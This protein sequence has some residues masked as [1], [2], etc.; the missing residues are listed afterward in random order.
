MDRLYV[1]NRRE[2][3]EPFLEPSHH[4]RVRV[5]LE[6]EVDRMNQHAR[7]AYPLSLRASIGAHPASGVRARSADDRVT[8]VGAGVTAHRVAIV[9]ILAEL[10]LDHAVTTAGPVSA[11]G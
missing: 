1:G 11:F 9:A 2:P 8:A 7:M 4:R 10:P 6:P 5:R 3:P